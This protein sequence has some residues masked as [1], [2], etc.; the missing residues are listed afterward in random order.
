MLLFLLVVLPFLSV[1][2]PLLLAR[3]SRNLLASAV[4]LVPASGL[5]LLLTQAKTVFNGTVLTFFVPWVSQLGLNLSL[6]LDGL[7]FLFALLIFGIGLLV[8]LYARYY[9]SAQEN[10]GRF[11]AYL[12]LFMGAMLGVVLSSNLLLMML[13]WELTSLASFL[14]I[15]FWSYR[16]D[17]RQ[18]ARMALA[19]TGGGGLALLAGV[20]II[21]RVVGSF[22]LDAVLAAG[23]LLQN[24]ALY[25]IALIL[26]LLG[27]FTKSAQF[28]FHFWLPHAM[29][30]PTP[31]SAYL[32]SATMV[33][34]G[35]FL[36]ARLY[37]ALS[38]TELWF[39]LVTFTGL[40]TLFIGAVTA[41]FQHDLKGLLAYSTISHL[42]L[43][44][45]LF[46][47]D[48]D[49]AL[50]AAIFHIINHATFK[51]SLFM[52]AGIIDHEVG[53]RDMR[54][55]SGLWKY[56]PHTAILAMV[57]SSAMAGVPLLNGFLSKEMFFSETL[58]QHLLGSFSWLVPAI[59][60]LAA[61]FS[62]SYSLRFI[63][64]VFFGAATTNLPHYP[65]HEPPR[66]MRVPVE[67]LVFLCLL[68]GTL[69]AFS[70]AAL[71]ASAAAA[72][73]GGD[74]P[75]YSLAVWHGFNLPLL[76]SLL[77]LLGG[78]L[79][80]ALR[81][82][83]F[84]WYAGLPPM[85]ARVVFER[86]L[87]R[88]RH[89]A[90]KFMAKLENGSL[91]RYV[92]CLLGAAIAVTAWALV[93]LSRMTGPVSLSTI[94][95]ITGLG[96]VLMATT[97][98]LTVYYHRQRLIALLM[99][100]MVGL[101]AAMV[102]ARFSAP[103]L[104]LT[105]L[106]VEV[107]TILLMLLIL[108]FLPATSPKESSSLHR[109][110]DLI[111]AI[112]GGTLIGLLIFAV[113]TREFTS[114]ADFYLAKSVS[115]GG[116]TNVVNV[117]LVDFRGFDTFGEI[118]VLAITAI[119]IAALLQGLQLPRAKL[120]SEG[121]AWS[122][123]ARPLMLQLLARF[124]FPLAILVSV[125]IFLRGH[126]EPGGG[127][128]AGLVTAVALVLLQI[129]YGQPWVM[130]RLPFNAKR[131]AGIG[132]L[133]AGATGLAS[134]WFG[135]PFLTTTFGHFNLP[136]IGE[137]ELASAMAFDLGVYLTVVGSTLLILSSLGHLGYTVEED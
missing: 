27:V 107:A 38:G 33:K 55:L 54:R 32:H 28:P 104:A 109:A 8:I 65:P 112:A 83:L 67:V 39:Y 90:R 99:L 124:V 131:L 84:A 66:Y 98:L 22:E 15:G 73:L 97:G 56:M 23:D 92:G 47:L 117:I 37:P 134:W 111:I 36:L 125:Y 4:A 34:A 11:F 91:Q 116:G 128:I 45:L 121:R 129:A 48:S 10:A 31:V 29:S 135:Y 85:N 122:P 50:V 89:E 130:E 110:R 49:L 78:I 108:Y 13:F 118:S 100:S 81:K 93:P 94:D 51:A 59:A 44:T 3:R 102:F 12:L 88:L 14:L 77:A 120:D 5:V 24:H 18:G 40:T 123:E 113:L 126:N 64:D 79:I 71:L 25:P 42:G 2:V 70:V 1:P 58:H 75:S 133:I 106:V 115:E 105:Q 95:P 57:A 6:R 103:D 19:V 35:V 16:R 68:V 127:F 80:Y 82:P 87:M 17:A 30:A 46:G 7:S 136:I 96:L 61:A 60:T 101:L 41:L 72:S 9:L 74:L 21:G 132:V 53:T 43:I 63:H 62:V 52:A 69:P 20:L 137:I 119:A 76:M 86:S 26:V 114:I